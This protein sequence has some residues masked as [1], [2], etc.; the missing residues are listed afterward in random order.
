[1]VLITSMLTMDQ[2]YSLADKRP[3]RILRCIQHMEEF[4]CL[5][6]VSLYLHEHYPQFLST[7][8]HP[9]SWGIRDSITRRKGGD[10]PA[11]L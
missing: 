5:I 4:L 7:K 3:N 11:L 1:M 9:T 8:E 10:C 2:Q 6:N